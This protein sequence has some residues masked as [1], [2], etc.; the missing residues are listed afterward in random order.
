MTDV[1]IIGSGGA[2]LSAAIWAKKNGAKK[3]TIINKQ[4]PTNASTAGAQ[5]GIN[6]VLY[7]EFDSV[8]LHI[9]DTIKSS[10]NL[11]N[12][13]S[14]KLLCENAKDTILWLDSI[15]VAFSKTEDGKFAQRKLGASKYNRTSYCSDYT[16]LKIIHSL[17]D[18]ALYI[19]VEFINEH[20]LL[21]LISDQKEVSGATFLDIKTAE[22]IEI[23]A[24]SVILATGG[25][26]EIFNGF[27][28]NSS[29]STGDGL[30]VAIR[31]GAQLTNLEFIQFHPTTLKHSSILISESA[32]AEGGYLVNSDG[33]RFIDELSTRDQVARAVYAQLEKGNEVYLDV[34]HLGVEKIKEDMPQERALAYEFEALMMESDLIPIKPSAHYSMG[35]IKTDINTKTSLKNLFAC[36]ECADVGIHGANRLGGNSLLEIISFGKIAG[37]NASLNANNNTKDITKESEQYISDKNFIQGVY[38]FPNRI[39]FYDRKEFMGKIFYR[40]IGLFRTDLNMKAV[41][42]HIRQWQKELPFMGISDKNK[43]YNKNLV[44]FIEFGNMLELSE[45]IVV[46]A[47]SRCESRGAHFRVDYPEQ[48]PSFEMNSISYKADGVLAVDFIKVEK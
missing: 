4:F 26:S 2:G 29:A 39:N 44:E 14:V 15:G 19:G 12:P 48:N 32:R 22:V 31:A 7:Q 34:R 18:Y 8:E 25:Y 30:S 28:T 17:Y 6:G 9:E 23:F 11:A 13:K 20:Y 33:E 40:N 36:G 1:L 43:I 37:I 10:S 45:A 21:N 27:S 42:Q 16:G 47:I 35:G 3:V 46:S 24:K 38:Y 5:G 41:L